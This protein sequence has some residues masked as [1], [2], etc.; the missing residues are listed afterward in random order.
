MQEFN[1]NQEQIEEF[2][3]LYGSAKFT[4][5]SQTSKAYGD[6]KID[7]YFKSVGFAA[8]VVSTIGIIAGFGFTAFGYV[9]SKF[10]FFCGE[11]IL[12]YSILHGLMW[13][14][15]V[16]SGEF[17]NLD[18][19]QKK[20]R[21]YFSER[22]KLFMEVWSTISTTGKIT[23]EKLFSLQKKDE[24]AVSLFAPKEENNEEKP[25]AIF[26]KRL[27]NLMIIGSIMLISSFFIYSLFW[28]M[29]CK[30]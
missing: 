26:S 19:S 17:R 23:Q 29:I 18:N 10:L 21:E 24:E 27:Y 20:Q 14:Q 22:N 6:H 2:Y 7:I 5:Q 1:L 15:S 16:Y 25:N 28:F 13:V 3:E 4:L 12:F 9:E 11:G 8:T 30:I